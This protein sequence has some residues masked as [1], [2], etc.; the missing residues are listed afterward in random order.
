MI[1]GGFLWLESVFD[2]RGKL[3]NGFGG[4]FLEPLYVSAILS[5]ECLILCP[6]EL[7]GLKSFR[8]AFVDGIFVGLES[9]AL[10]KSF[11]D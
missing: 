4:L 1:F 9:L 3:S 10:F 7:G 11:S 6:L 8:Y 2:E 5:C